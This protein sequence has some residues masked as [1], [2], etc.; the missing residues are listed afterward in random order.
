VGKEYK[1][2]PQRN[3][4]RNPNPQAKSMNT[5]PCYGSLF[6]RMARHTP[7]AKQPF[8]RAGCSAYRPGIMPTNEV[9]ERDPGKQAQ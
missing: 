8:R 7:D 9:E 6:E 4:R 2:E 5:Q 1:T 3:Q